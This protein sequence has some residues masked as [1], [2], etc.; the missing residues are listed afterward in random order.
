[1]LLLQGRILKPKHCRAAL[2]EMM[3]PEFQGVGFQKLFCQQCIYSNFL[4]K[5]KLENVF[6]YAN[7]A[8]WRAKRNQEA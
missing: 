7:F 8:M 4:I 3:Y 1:M 2:G 5:V 6:E